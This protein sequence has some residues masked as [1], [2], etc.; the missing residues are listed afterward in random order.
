VYIAFHFLLIIFS[1]VQMTSKIVVVGA[2]IIG[3]TT[4]LS[5]AEQGYQVSVIDQADSI[6][7]GASGSNGAQLS[8]SYTDAMASPDMLRSLPKLLS[9]R[10]PAFRFSSEI[11][12]EL[13]TWGTRFLRNCTQ[14]RSDI[15]T[16]SVLEIA[17]RSRAIMHA[18]CRKYKF[19]FNHRSAGK[20]HLYEEQSGLDK[21][22]AR[23]ELKNASGS[24]QKILSR[25]QVFEIEPLLKHIEGDLVGAVYSPEDEVGDAAM[26]ATAALKK[27]TEISGGQVHLG[28]RLIDFIREGSSIRA[29]KTSAGDIE[30]DV[31]VLCAG[32][33][34]RSLASILGVNLSILPVS[35]Y[36][37]TYSALDGTPDTSITDTSRKIVICRVGNKVRIAGMAD[38]GLVTN[39]P[40]EVR[41]QT[42]IRSAQ[43]RFPLAADYSGEANPWVGIRPMTPDSRPVIRQCGADNVYVNC[44]HGMLGWTLAAG[45]AN[46]LREQIQDKEAQGLNLDRLRQMANQ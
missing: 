17:L 23:V 45:T 18:W 25:A 6:A 43:N 11:N 7:A 8:Y 3:A 16:L 21:A 27:A 37:L 14:F 31:V 2:G 34:T 28:V 22:R 13:M 9:G 10:D 36:S 12:R 1:R 39:K 29:L 35:G 5:L 41:I 30:A 44:G 32:F 20:L 4:A 42:L 15:N 26:F 24:K 19:E 33:Q 40:P 38:M 46:I